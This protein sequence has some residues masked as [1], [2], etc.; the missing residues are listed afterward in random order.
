MGIEVSGWGQSQGLTEATSVKTIG[1]K[2]I[3][4]AHA[5]L[6]RHATRYEPGLTCPHLLLQLM[7][8]AIGHYLA[9]RAWERFEDV[10]ECGM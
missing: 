3:S 6:D 2:L 4:T 5:L 7:P 9:T 8:H 1:K 10:V